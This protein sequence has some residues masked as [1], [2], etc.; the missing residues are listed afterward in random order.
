MVSSNPSRA[1]SNAHTCHL[2]RFSQED[3][4]CVFFQ[5]SKKKSYLF[6]QQS[7][8]VTPSLASAVN[9]DMLAYLPASP[10]MLPKIWCC[11]RGARVH[12][13]RGGANGRRIRRASKRRRSNPPSA[14]PTQPAQTTTFGGLIVVFA[15]GHIAA[16]QMSSVRP[17]SIWRLALLP[18]PPNPSPEDLATLRWRGGRSPLPCEAD[19]PLSGTARPPFPTSVS[20]RA[21]SA[22]FAQGGCRRA[23][24]CRA[25]PRRDGAVLSVHGGRPTAECEGRRCG[26]C[27]CGSPSPTGPHPPRVDCCVHDNTSERTVAKRAFSAR[28][29]S[30]RPLF[31]TAPGRRAG[32]Q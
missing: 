22:G 4:D 10:T 5:F 15:I 8:K 24:P 27:P 16:K 23:A 3:R 19:R 26:V 28:P 11:G 2:L 13:R 32:Q 6:H 14:R 7:A 17:S 12:P 18:P 31:P 25:A 30:T 9:C 1:A 20:G 29:S 21:P